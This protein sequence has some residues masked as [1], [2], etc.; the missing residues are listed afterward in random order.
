MGDYTLPR[1]KKIFDSPED[2]I[3]II[4]ELEAQ[5]IS[6]LN[7]KEDIRLVNIKLHNELDK[8]LMLKDDIESIKLNEDIIDKMRY[9]KK[10]KEKMIY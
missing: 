1:E 2:F 7:Q 6:S 10:L 3:N 4:E 5:I 8:Y 9:L